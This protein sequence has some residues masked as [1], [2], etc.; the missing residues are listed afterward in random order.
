MEGDIED[1]ISKLKPLAE[2]YKLLVCAADEF[3]NIALAHKKDVKKA[4]DRA[5]NLGDIID[6][7]ISTL[8]KIMPGWLK[9][10][11]MHS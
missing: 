11:K 6:D 5:D 9:Q 8:D 7:V 10:I 1:L 3:N 2:S 4:I